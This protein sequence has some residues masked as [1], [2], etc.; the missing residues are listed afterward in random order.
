MKQSRKM[1][2]SFFVYENIIFLI[3][4]LCCIAVLDYSYS[5]SC[6]HTRNVVS[7]V[8]TSAFVSALIPL[9]LNIGRRMHERSILNATCRQIIS[10]SVLLIGSLNE[11]I[12]KCGQKPFSCYS[13]LKDR[14]IVS[15]LNYESFSTFDELFI[16]FIQK[17]NRIAALNYINKTDSFDFIVKKLNKTVAKAESDKDYARLFDNLII[18][19]GIVGII[20]PPIMK[21]NYI[22]QFDAGIKETYER[23][24]KIY[25][26]NTDEYIVRCIECDLSEKQHGIDK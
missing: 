21:Q 25:Y 23:I 2:L 6:K 19:I 4:A 15:A 10:D 17:L 9:F 26:Q 13:D 18:I 12:A 22:K 20:R 14:K 16:L 1:K 5:I 24:K 8:T 3:V 7:S 11:H